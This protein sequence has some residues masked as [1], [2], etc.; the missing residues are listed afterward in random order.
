VAGKDYTSDR[1]WTGAHSQEATRADPARHLGES[2]L[3]DD[4]WRSDDH[5]CLGLARLRRLDIAHSV[6]D[7]G[8]YRWSRI[9]TGRTGIA[10]WRADEQQGRV[11]LVR[12]DRDNRSAIPH[13]RT[14]LG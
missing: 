7:G 1:A 13:N 12:A 8:V 11:S 4:F 6:L 5:P 14:A 3:P 10:Q 9:L 2:G